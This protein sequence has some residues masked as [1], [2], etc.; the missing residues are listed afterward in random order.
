MYDILRA[1]LYE[2]ALRDFPN[3][4]NVDDMH[5]LTLLME[6][7]SLIKSTARYLQD[8]MQLRCILLVMSA[9]AIDFDFDQMLITMYV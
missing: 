2:N 7:P 1:P 8:A 5:A 6:T 9:G 3:F 4:L